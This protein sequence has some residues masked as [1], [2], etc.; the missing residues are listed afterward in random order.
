MYTF[1]T[2]FDAFI[3]LWLL[4]CSCLRT[5]D[6]YLRMVDYFLAECERQNIRYAELHFTPF[7][8]EKLGIGGLPVLGIVTSRLQAA[9]FS[10]G[11][12]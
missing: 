7:N 10:R 12:R 11:D 1:T 3:S 6:D 5:P 2:S 4:M 9:Q 8:H